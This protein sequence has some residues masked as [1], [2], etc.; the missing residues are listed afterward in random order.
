MKYT[1]DDIARMAG[2]S[3]ATVSRV[4]NDPDIVSKEKVRRVLAAAKKVGYSPD[5]NASALRRSGTGT[6]LF[7]EKRATHETL[8]KRFYYWHYAD[9]LK[10]VKEVTDEHAYQLNLHSFSSPKDIAAI[11]KRNLC[12]GIIVYDVA[13][14]GTMES[15]NS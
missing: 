10:A 1:R 13:D 5:K 11:G 4:Y 12:D 6:I 8:D 3:T 15:R 2:V 14:R 9:V 7:L